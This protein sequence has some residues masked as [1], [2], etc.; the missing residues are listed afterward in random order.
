MSVENSW[1]YIGSYRGHHINTIQDV[2]NRC[3]LKILGNRYSF[4]G[5][6]TCYTVKMC[7]SELPVL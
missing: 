5:V 2:N 1:K 3:Q 4:I 7:P 6:I